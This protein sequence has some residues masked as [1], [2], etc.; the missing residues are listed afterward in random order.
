MQ[1][2]LTGRQERSFQVRLKY[3]Q[4]LCQ[5]RGT[6]RAGEDLDVSSGLVAVKKQDSAQISKDQKE[7]GTEDAKQQAALDG[8][9]R[10][11]C[12]RFAVF[13]SL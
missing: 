9:D 6:D 7:N 8:A 5:D 12:D 4:A 2:Y 11:S 1:P 10:K 13:S 3:W